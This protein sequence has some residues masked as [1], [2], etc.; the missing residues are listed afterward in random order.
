MKK[1]IFHSNRVYNN[2]SETLSPDASKKHVPRWFSSASRSWLDSNGNE[3]D[4]SFGGKVLSFKACPALMDAFVMG[5]MLTTP[6]DIYFYKEAGTTK[7][8]TPPGLED[9][10]GA[11]PRM[12]DFPTPE[13]YEEDHFH[14][15]PNWM[16]ELPKGYSAIYTSPL[17]RFDLPFLTISGVI[18]N[19]D[20]NTPGLMPF[21]IKKNFYGMIPAGTPYAQVIPFKREDWQSELV[22]HTYE[23]IN[24]RHSDQAS[25][26]RI[27]EGGAYKKLVWKKKIFLGEK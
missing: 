11:R 4:H 6:C 16:P 8:K 3:T 14:W 21:F 23:E 26:F 10:C 1:I 17:N 19:D 24:K 2:L 27:P 25:K 20:M 13:G 5:Y 15:Y 12:Q 7:V 22:M 18:D 9:F